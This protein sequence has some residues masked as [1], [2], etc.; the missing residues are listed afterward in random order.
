MG[1]L[2]SSLTIARHIVERCRPMRIV[3]LLTSIG[4]GAPSP[5]PSLQSY[6]RRSESIAAGHDV[7]RP[8]SAEAQIATT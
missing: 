1:M 5:A 7:A 8:L 4:M 2:S 6:Q 3:I